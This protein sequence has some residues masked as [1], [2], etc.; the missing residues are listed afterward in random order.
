MAAV[1]AS[2]QNLVQ[3]HAMATAL[4]LTLIPKDVLLME[5]GR[6][7]GRRMVKRVGDK[8]YQMLTCTLPYFPRQLLRETIPVACVME[9]TTKSMRWELATTSEVAEVL[10]PLLQRSGYVCAGSTKAFRTKSER[11]I[12]VVAKLMSPFEISHEV[13]SFGVE[14]CYLNGMYVLVTQDGEMHF[15]KDNER[16]ELSVSL[17]ERVEL[18]AAVKKDLMELGESGQ[19][20][21]PNWW[22]QLG[23]E[24][25]AT[26]VELLLANPT[27]RGGPRKPQKACAPR[28]PRVSREAFEIEAIVGEKRGRRKT[29]IMYLVRWS[30]YDPTW[31]PWRINGQVGDP[32]ETWE[33]A[34]RL[35]GTAALEAWRIAASQ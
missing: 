25:K 9:D 19:P 22:R 17:K 10:G 5:I 18:R 32:I 35:R 24:D 1:T 8:V 34:Q 7:I 29:N 13:S 21:S 4:G 31:E 15:P 14:R 30:G 28:Q 12:R 33:P 3:V 23:K 27:W 16:R 11:V 6:A 2:G 26:E 20:L